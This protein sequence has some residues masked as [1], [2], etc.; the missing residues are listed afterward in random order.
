MF[1]PLVQFSW[2]KQN[3]NGRLEELPPAEGEQP[4][5]TGCTAAILLINADALDKHKYVCSV[6][7]EGGTVEAQK[8]QV[9]P[10]LPPSP[11]PSPSSSPS[12]SPSPSPPPSPSPS[13]S[14][15][16]PPSPPPAASVPSQY[17]VKLLCVLYTV[18]IVKSL[19]FCCGLCLSL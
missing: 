1:P 14:P 19:V 13:S 18:L 2:Q 17:Q 5:L 9:L 6:R 15:P 10:A 11:S 3:E 7:H 12:S 16:P 8:E 4:K